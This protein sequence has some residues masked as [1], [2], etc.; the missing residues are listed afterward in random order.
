MQH[1]NPSPHEH[2]LENSCYTFRRLEPEFEKAA[3]HRTGMGH[4]EVG[5]VEFHAFGIAQKARHE[6]GR[7]LKQLLLE[8]CA[9]KRDLPIH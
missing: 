2:A 4:S 7:Q 3:T 8:R 5:T 6:T 9:V 1:H